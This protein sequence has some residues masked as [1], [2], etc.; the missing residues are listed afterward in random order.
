MSSLVV[1]TLWQSSLG[2]RERLVKRQATK[3]RQ[4]DGRTGADKW[5]RARSPCRQ[6]FVSEPPASLCHGHLPAA[7]LEAL[8]SERLHAP[9]AGE[10][11]TLPGM[12]VCNSQTPPRLLETSTLGANITPTDD[13]LQMFSCRHAGPVQRV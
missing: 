3:T 10:R 6:V 5:A 1:L 12:R 4:L 2:Y 11:N 8:L 7:A 9:Y 13:N